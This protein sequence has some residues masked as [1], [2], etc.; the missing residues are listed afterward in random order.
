MHKTRLLWNSFA[1]GSAHLLTTVE[2]RPDNLDSNFSSNNVL[3]NIHLSPPIELFWGVRQTPCQWPTSEC[4]W[5]LHLHQIWAA[6]F[7]RP[8]CGPFQWLSDNSKNSFNSA[9]ELANYDLVTI[10][11]CSNEIILPKISIHLVTTHWMVVRTRRKP[12]CRWNLLHQ[13]IFQDLHQQ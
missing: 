13:P 8:R 6:P 5:N 7:L 2:L 9:H 12:G 10:S 1:A 3:Q 11:K 4:S